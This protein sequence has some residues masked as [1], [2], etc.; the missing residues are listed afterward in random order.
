L[1]LLRALGLR[2]PGAAVI[3]CPTCGRTEMNVIAIANEIETKLEQYY[4]QKPGGARPLVAVMGCVVNGP[5][6]A[7]HA[8]VAVCGGKG[9]AALFV[10]GVNTGTIPEA[11][12]VEAVLAEVKRMVEA[13]P[14]QESSSK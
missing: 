12:I 9:K 7:R 10:K 2:E 5:G 1:E 6:E 8:D 13:P 11:R 4:R 14:R 3:A